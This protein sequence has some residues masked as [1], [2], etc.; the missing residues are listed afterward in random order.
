[1]QGKTGVPDKNIMIFVPKNTPK[2][3]T[4]KGGPVAAQREGR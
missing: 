1:L 4:K 2:F 3:R